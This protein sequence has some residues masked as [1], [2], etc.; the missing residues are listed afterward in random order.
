[1][2]LS[3]SGAGTRA[4]KD[5][6]IYHERRSQTIFFLSIFRFFA[7][8]RFDATRRKYY[9]EY[10]L[11]A[12]SVFS[13]QAERPSFPYSSAITRWLQSLEETAIIL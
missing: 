11:V 13:V 2:T 9:V 5:E 6:L 12:E 10:L 4:R 3:F 8:G 1:M 7:I